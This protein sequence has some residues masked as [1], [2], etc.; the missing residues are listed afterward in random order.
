MRN[1]SLCSNAPKANSTRSGSL[2]DT[3]PIPFDFA[4]FLRSL[5]RIVTSTKLYR[6]AKLACPSSVQFQQSE[7]EAFNQTHRYTSSF[8]LRASVAFAFFIV[9]AASVFA[10]TS[11]VTHPRNAL[12][13]N[14]I[15]ISVAASA[16][17]SSNGQPVSV[18]MPAGTQ[19]GSLIVKLNGK[20]VSSHFQESPCSSGVCSSAVLSTYEG[21]RDGKNVLSATSKNEDGTASSSR[22]HF[23]G[24]VS[25]KA[26]PMALSA[27]ASTG[28][29]PT[30]SSFLPPT[31]ALTTLTPGGAPTNGNWI[32]VGSQLQLPVG[33]CQ[34]TYSV[35][36]LDRQTLQQKTGAPEISPRCFATS[37]TLVPYLQSLKGLNDLVIVGTLQGQTTDAA[38]YNPN[39]NGSIP[40]DT[41]SIGGRIYNCPKCSWL[42]PVN[43]TDMPLQY[44]AIGVPGAEPGSAFENYST[45]TNTNPAGANGA[46]F[47]DASGNYNFQPSGSVEYMV[48][49][50]VTGTNASIQINYAPSAPNYEVVYQP[51][52]IASS[53][54]G[55]W[56]L[57]LDR[58]T[59]TALPG[60]QANAPADG[61]IVVP[62]CGQY[63]P[64][65]AGP[66]QDPTQIGNLRVALQGVTNSQ[67]A[68][69]TTVGAAGWDTPINMAN[70]NGGDNGTLDLAP[71]LQ[72]YGIPD[73]LILQTAGSTF[74]MIGTPGLGGPLNGHNILSTSYLSQQ[75][76]TGYVHGTLSYDNHGLFEPDHSQQEPG[77][78]SG[79]VVDTANVE[80]GLALSQQP[81]EWPEFVNPLATGNS[82]QGQ[83]QAYQYLSYYLLNNWYIAG[84]ANADGTLSPGVT[85]PYAYDIHYFF[86]GSLNT[87]IDYHTYDPLNVS[88]PSVPWTSPDGTTLNFTQQEFNS[89]KSQLHNETVDLNNVL[90]LFVSG[91]TNLKDVIAAGNSNT[92]LALL[93]AFS[94]VSANINEQG[95]ALNQTTPVKV[96][97][98]HIAN[99]ISSDISPY[100]SLLSGGAITGNDIKTADRVLGYIHDMFKMAGSIGGGLASGKQ[101]STS[102]LPRLDYSLDTTVGQ[103]AGLSLQSQYLAG[104]DATLDA[105]TGDWNKL[106]AIGGPP[107]TGQTLFSSTQVA[108]NAA[109]AQI[110]TAE[111]K[112]MYMSV[113]PSVF[114]VHYWNMTSSGATLP[115]FGYTSSG[116]IGSCSAFYPAISGGSLGAAVT[117]PTYGG[118]SYLEMWSNPPGYG[119]PF[120]Y[121]TYNPFK[122]W[123]VLSL[124]FINPGHSDASAQAMT[125]SLASILFG[126]SGGVNLSLDEF[127]SYGGPMD[128]PV[129]GTSG[130]V[131]N[132]SSA[133]IADNPPYSP[134][135]NPIGIATGNICS[136]NEV[137]INVSSVENP[138]SVGSTPPTDPSA[139]ATVT[140]LL[141]PATAVVG[142]NLTLVAKV[143]KSGSSPAG[144]SVQFRDGSTVMQTVALDA[145]GSASYTVNTLALGSHALVASY[146]STDGSQPSNSDTK[147][148]IV[149]ANSPDMLLSLSQL[150]VNVGYGSTSSSTTLKIQAVSGMSGAVNY[151]CTGLPLGMACT[152]TPASGMLTDGG[153][154]TTTF[155]ITGTA[156]ATS[157]FGA[158]KG[159]GLILLTVPL[160]LVANIR[161]N[162]AAMVKGILPLLL[163]LVVIGGAVGCGGNSATSPTLK[164]AG[165]KTVLVSATCGSLTKTTALVVNVQ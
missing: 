106:Q 60:C 132:M 146:A 99:M 93:Q 73:K 14:Q 65:G 17:G 133:P 113:I 49:P 116:K 6:R 30:L 48:Q 100:A 8:N 127:V 54:Y 78:Q 21:V 88:Y 148:T 163:L 35:I 121:S 125:N 114:Q 138:P 123:F 33:A 115:N 165:T 153:T 157:S 37:E 20:D 149:Y 18:Q 5:V 52:T 145:T 26:S 128:L 4:C 119:Y 97:P 147:T 120:K 98:W 134:N 77:F 36:V 19:A 137:N 56:L 51:P 124:P 53:T 62:N 44:I 84:Q 28:T 112:S 7:F 59:L 110:T 43:S 117:Y 150:S 143:T 50:G 69:L 83:M 142:D 162:R 81:V 80:L 104:F 15:H 31:V 9:S 25:A 79:T 122:D 151:A 96:S 141:V 68:I 156:P 109:I 111:Q 92:A 76:Q 94:T 86:T 90:S 72:S 82:L 23:D 67:L 47:E 144:G 16:N 95:V 32:Q 158:I 61:T 155:T 105:I 135:T 87:L 101:S 39:V 13:P 66:S 11:P 107:V 24:A 64:T 70:A 161:R 58:N 102:D 139:N 75:G 131:I 129:T 126:N 74:T 12:A 34:S 2:S 40:F 130:S 3:D 42:P 154:A 10:Q 91:S 152:F 45:A 160:A 27:S 57:V 108:Q 103:M 159:W 85:G 29:L 41:T 89:V 164:D 63:F 118:T 46:L 22:M 140:T 55:F 1:Q 136:Q 71:V 38:A